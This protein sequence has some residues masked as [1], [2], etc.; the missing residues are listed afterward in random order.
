MIV[1]PIT[2][3]CSKCQRDVFVT[4]LEFPADQASECKIDD[5]PINRKYITK[6]PDFP[7]LDEIILA[8]QISFVEADEK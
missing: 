3:R 2:D 7:E 8:H 1:R 6:Y 5:C 4:A